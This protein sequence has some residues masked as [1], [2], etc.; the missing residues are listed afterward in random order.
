MSFF[1]SFF[2]GFLR[3]GDNGAGI[4]GDFYTGNWIVRSQTLKRTRK[5][6]NTWEISKNT[7][8]SS[9]T[10]PFN[11]RIGPYIVTRYRKGP[12]KNA[13][14]CENTRKKIACFRDHYPEFRVLFKGHYVSYFSQH[15][16]KP[17]AT[18]HLK[19]IAQFW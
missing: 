19:I 13:K 17:K 14:F 8:L 1:F 2:Y 3:R 5:L 18:G 12:I 4:T 6:L 10:W 7:A 15:F 11:N 9:F 16:E